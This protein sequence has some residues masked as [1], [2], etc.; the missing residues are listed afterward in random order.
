[1]KIPVLNE[2]S[3]VTVLHQQTWRNGNPSPHWVFR[4]NCTS[5]TNVKKWKSQS[6]LSLPL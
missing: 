2:P 1:M 3:V 5:P 6:T 4:C